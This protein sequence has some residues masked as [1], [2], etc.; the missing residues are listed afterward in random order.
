MNDILDIYTKIKLRIGSEIMVSYYRYGYKIARTIILEDICD[1][2]YIYGY[3]DYGEFMRFDFFNNN[4]LIE[5]VWDMENNICLYINK[6]VCKE[7]FNGYLIDDGLLEKM[8]LDVLGIEYVNFDN[9][10]KNGFSYEYIKRDS[11]IEKYIAKKEIV[12]YDELFFST[13][14]REEFETF[15]NMLV[16][17]LRNYARNKGLDDKLKFL[18][19]GKVAMIYELGDKIIKIG[20]PRRCNYVPYC[21]WILQPIINKNFSFDGYPIHIEVTQ[22]V[23]TLKKM[24]KKDRR[25]GMDIFRKKLWELKVKL[26]EIGLK[27]SDLHIDNIG[28]LLEDNMIHYDMIDAMVCDDGITSIQNNNDLM[29]LEEGNFVIIDLDSL[30][31]EDM[32]KY[33]EYLKKIGYDKKKISN[34]YFHNKCLVR[35]PY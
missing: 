10:I 34:L 6:N 33:T 26:A 2:E 19:A 1:F 17:E 22:K 14:E 11:L 27:S 16:D 3:T 7:I 28:I 4:T 5:S 12:K 23:L 8:K 29:V 15:F 20:K 13:K 31:I 32:D 9:G 30:V 35:K 24:D 18:G 21:E 25:I